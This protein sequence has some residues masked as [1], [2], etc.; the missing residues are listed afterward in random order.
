MSG[1]AI[2]TE[3]RVEDCLRV[4]ASTKADDL[5]N[6]IISKIEQGEEP[7]LRAIGPNSVHIAF[8]ACTV[9]LAQLASRGIDIVIRPAEQTVVGGRGDK[10][11][12]SVFIILK[13]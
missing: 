9:A 11:N 1:A 10:L 13:R 6:A 4:G 12:A 2:L 7:K 5:A 3:E 8:L